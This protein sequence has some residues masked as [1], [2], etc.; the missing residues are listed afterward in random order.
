MIMNG[1]V[2]GETASQNMAPFLWRGVRFSRRERRCG[3]GDS[4]ADGG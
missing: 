3:I 4:H 1:A 2:S